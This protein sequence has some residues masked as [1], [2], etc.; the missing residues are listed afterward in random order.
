MLPVS[1]QTLLVTLPGAPSLPDRGAP[2]HPP[3][4]QGL[5]HPLCDTYPPWSSHVTLCVRQCSICRVMGWA[6]GGSICH[7]SGVA[8]DVLA[9]IL[10][11]SSR[12][13]LDCCVE[14]DSEAQCDSLSRMA[15]SYL[16]MS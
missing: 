15:H 6:G 9:V 7:L 2:A 1:K 16:M 10:S 4:V 11:A 5:F 12:Q 13:D 14:K 8:W 3:G